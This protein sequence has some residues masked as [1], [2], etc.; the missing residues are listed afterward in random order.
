M[1]R[2][3]L[4]ARKY[5]GSSS[6]G[7]MVIRTQRK[8]RKNLPFQQQSVV[9]FFCIAQYQGKQL[10]GVIKTTKRDDNRKSI[11]YSVKL[12]AIDKP[13]LGRFFFKPSLARPIGCVSVCVCRDSAKVS[14]SLLL[15]L[16]PFGQD[17]PQ[18]SFCPGEP[19]SG[20]TSCQ[21]RNRLW[22]L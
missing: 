16:K 21:G 2:S 19:S 18:S 4:H 8:A 9:E 7:R 5:L 15:F 1:R 13:M 20:Q 22:H 10:G 11:A 12:F 14:V 6:Y 3:N 17:G